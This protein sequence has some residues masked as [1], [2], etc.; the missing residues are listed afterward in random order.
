MN[1]ENWS[2]RL[3][4]RRFLKVSGTLAAGMALIRIGG[5]SRALGQQTNSEP[6]IKMLAAG[7]PNAEKLG[8]RLGV[9]IY[10]FN[11]FTLFQ[12]IEMTASLGLKYI[13][14]FCGQTISH[15]YPEVFGAGIL[16]V[17]GLS[18]RYRKFS[19]ERQKKVKQKMAD[20]GLKHTSH[21]EKI[22]DP[23]DAPKVFEF[24]KEMDLEMLI[25]DPPRIASGDGDMA[26]YDKL[27]Q[28][29]AIKMALTNHRKP[30]PYWNPDFM[31]E[32][33]NGRSKWIG[34]SADFGHFMRG[35]YAPM[36]VVKKYADAGRMYQFHFRDVN[37]L[38]HEGRDVPLGEGVADIRGILTE[39]HRRKLQPLFQLEY[40]S[41][42]DNPMLDLVPSV[43]CFNEVC[44]ELVAKG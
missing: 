39:L 19:A 44:G 40:E 38:G 25:T 42:F 29:Y 16:A 9:Q 33:C 32:D 3:D 20:A 1:N 30:A 12:A 18:V 21:Y 15:D 6:K 17:D 26:F 34:G 4:R 37:K 22:Y 23:K 10:T 2:K 24:C 5:S 36:E 13:E 43:K 28:E 14:T 27:C 11:K 8:W 7:V 41:N 35:G 31:V